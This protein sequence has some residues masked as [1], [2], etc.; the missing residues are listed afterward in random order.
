MVTK[1]EKNQYLEN[2]RLVEINSELLDNHLSQ[3]ELHHRIT[4]LHNN[5]EAKTGF[6]SENISYNMSASH[7]N[8]A[9]KHVTNRT[10]SEWKWRAVPH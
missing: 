10:N 5:Q 9:L 2:K 8:Y 3:S 6:E 1:T 4:T 7:L